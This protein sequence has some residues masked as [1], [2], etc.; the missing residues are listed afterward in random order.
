MALVIAMVMVLAMGTTVFAATQTKAL[1][2][3]DADNA[4]ITINNPAK[5]ETY[6]LFKLFDATVR[7]DG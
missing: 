5:G 3:A 6:E 4:T 7:E 2:P 1:S